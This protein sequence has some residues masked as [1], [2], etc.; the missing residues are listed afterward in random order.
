MKIARKQFGFT[1]LEMIV[2]VA[3]IVLLTSI[4]ISVATR[5]D[6][7]S[8]ERLTENTLGLLNA[9]LEQ[10]KDFGYEL[11]YNPIWLPVIPEESDFFLGLQFP[12]DCNGFTAADVATTLGLVLNAGVGGVVIPPA[13]ND[14]NYSGSE[15]LYFFLS[16]VPANKEIL[17]RIGKSLITNIGS[18]G[19]AMD[20]EINGIKY[21]LYR[22]VD[23]WGT[24]LRYDYYYD[25]APP[26][27]NINKINNMKN[28][29]RSFPL[30]IS[31]GPDKVFDTAD[32][33]KN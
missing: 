19:Q 6:S 27:N 17:S 14:P 18:G 7:Q 1:L 30:I 10:Y 16:K 13:G 26:F 29:K 9:A 8:K 4:V 5:I 2:V 23:A 21:P 33:I 20:I 15:V 12:I 28:S 32:D 22:F 24:T 25:E 11:K 3:V 31:A